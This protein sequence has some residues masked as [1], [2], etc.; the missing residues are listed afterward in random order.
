[1]EIFKYCNILYTHELLKKNW[2]T[3]KKTF[4]KTWIVILYLSL[5]TGQFNLLLRLL[6]KVGTAENKFSVS[7]ICKSDRDNTHVGVAV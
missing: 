2:N 7:Y 1:M 5:V 3:V 4:V 6:H